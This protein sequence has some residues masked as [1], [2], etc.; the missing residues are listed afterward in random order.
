M[1]SFL[2]SLAITTVRG[3]NGIPSR[4]QEAEA[5]EIFRQHGGTPRT[6]EALALGI[7]PC[8]LYALR[9]AGDLERL[10]RDL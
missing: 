1:K 10:S 2:S 7:H 6:N 9:D 5:F 4:I 3:G 8:T